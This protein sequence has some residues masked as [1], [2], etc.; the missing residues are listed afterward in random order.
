MFK[1]IKIL[2]SG[3]NVP[4]PQIL[5]KTLTSKLKAGVAVKMSVGKATACAATE[6][7][8]Y[9][10]LKTP[11]DS[12]SKVLC[13]AVNENM[14]FETFINADPSALSVGDKVTIGNDSDNLPGCVSATTTSGVATIVDL[15][16][17]KAPGDKIIVKF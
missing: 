9:I 1:L 11:E 10:V 3:T 5:S 2:N 8:S 4:E 14:L 13:H 16:D 7:P 12:Q 17:A 6:K 15:L